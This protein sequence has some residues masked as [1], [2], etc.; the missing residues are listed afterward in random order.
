[1]IG[2]TKRAFAIAALIVA[3]GVSAVELT[4]SPAQ[5]EGALSDVTTRIAAAFEVAATMPAVQ[6]V[7]V[8][9]AV[10]GDLPVPSDCANI[11]GDAQAECMD[12][13]YEVPSQPS[14]VVE[15]RSGSTSTLIRMDSLTVAD[16]TD[17]HRMSSE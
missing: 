12:V 15:T 9:M 5:A 4:R 13:A 10:K 8:P 7:S 16:M 11:S 3:T 6:Q 14:I 1:M 17:G 2:H